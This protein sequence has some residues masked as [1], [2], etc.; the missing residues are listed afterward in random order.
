VRYSSPGFTADIHFGT[1]GL[2]ALY[3]GF[4][5]RLA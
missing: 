5:E 1:D 3:E 2:V 4:L